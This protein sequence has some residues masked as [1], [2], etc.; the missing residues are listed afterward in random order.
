ML[1]W[2]LK[3]LARH[4]LFIYRVMFIILISRLFFIETNS[5][6][7]ILELIGALTILITSITSLIHESKSFVKEAKETL[8]SEDN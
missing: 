5:T 7:C 6:A 3:L 8:L 4:E 2:T 1:M